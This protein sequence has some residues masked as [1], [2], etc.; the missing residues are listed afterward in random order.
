MSARRGSW[1]LFSCVGD[2]TSL[3]SLALVAVAQPRAGRAR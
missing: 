3:E 2:L 1:V